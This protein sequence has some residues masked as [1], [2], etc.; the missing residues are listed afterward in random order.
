MI[1][2]LAEILL[3]ENHDDFYAQVAGFP[4]TTALHLGIT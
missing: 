2:K 1:L 4:V 3:I